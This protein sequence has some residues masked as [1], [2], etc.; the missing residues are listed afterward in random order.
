MVLIAGSFGF[1]F[2]MA[3]FFELFTRLKFKKQLR[4]KNRQIENLEK[5]ILNLNHASIVPSSEK[6][7]SSLAN[8]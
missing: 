7:P 1:G 3:W 6:N 4:L 5:E 2:L 8:S